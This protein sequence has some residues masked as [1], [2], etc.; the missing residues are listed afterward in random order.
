MVLCMEQHR[1]KQE[2]STLRSRVVMRHSVPAG[3]DQSRG[4]R[5]RSF[6]N[7]AILRRRQGLVYGVAQERD[8]V[9]G[10]AVLLEKWRR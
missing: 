10:N 3:E 5:S 7:G 2:E 9:L 8:P 1:V 4:E 6:F